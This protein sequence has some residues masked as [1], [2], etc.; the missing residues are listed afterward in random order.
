M[1]YLRWRHFLPKYQNLQQKH[2]QATSPPSWTSEFAPDM[3]GCR[4]QCCN[5]QQPWFA[6][7][8]HKKNSLTQQQL[9][10]FIYTWK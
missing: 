2:C 8:A 7:Q 10:Q 5:C 4:E 6:P 9:F 1:L 3:P